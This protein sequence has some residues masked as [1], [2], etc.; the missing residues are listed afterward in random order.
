ML[1]MATK[2]PATMRALALSHHCNPSEY[3]VATLPVPQI[4]QP[5]E[6]LIRVHAASVN[7]IDVKLASGFVPISLCKTAH[8]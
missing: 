2:I 4:T 8:L 1:K 6:L 7:P 5:D 3:N